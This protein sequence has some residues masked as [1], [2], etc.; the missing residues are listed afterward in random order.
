MVSFIQPSEVADGDNLPSE[1]LLHNSVYIENQIEGYRTLSVQGRELIGQ[2]VN[3]IPRTGVDGSVFINKRYPERYITVF[4]KLEAETRKGFREKFNRL[5]RILTGGNRT[6]RFRDELDYHFTG[7]LENVDTVPPGVNS[8]VSSFTLLCTDPFKYKDEVTVSG[9]SPIIKRSSL[10]RIL[11]S[12][13]VLTMLSSGT[14]DIVLTHGLSSIRL[15]NMNYQKGDLI[16]FDFTTFNVNSE[17]VNLL[18]RMDLS[19]NFESFNL[20]NG[21]PVTVSPGANIRVDY[22]EVD[23]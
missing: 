16:F 21:L 13:I 6:F 20:I 14:G 19:S 15:R 8:V 11:P 4:Y 2:E 22:K 12:R 7:V 18:R 9:L 1:A 23:L 10:Y 17:S 5:N 3:T